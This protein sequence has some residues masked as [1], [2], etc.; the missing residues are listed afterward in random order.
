MAFLNAVGPISIT[1]W[2]QLFA[3]NERKIWHIFPSFWQ[4]T[5]SKLKVK[6]HFPI[7]FTYYS[8]SIHVS[9]QKQQLLHRTLVP[10]PNYHSFT[11][12]LQWHL[13]ILAFLW[14]VGTCIKSVFGSINRYFKSSKAYSS[15]PCNSY[16]NALSIAAFFL[17]FLHSSKTGLLRRGFPSSPIRAGL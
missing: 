7:D 15:T 12:A 1:V 4:T 6:L 16:Q 5:V 9:I 11:T 10:I 2:P 8:H 3:E 17:R 14:G 13:F